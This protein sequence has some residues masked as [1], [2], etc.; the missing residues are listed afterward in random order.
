MSGVE[1]SHLVF[2]VHFIESGD[3]KSIKQSASLTFKLRETP[4]HL[5]AHMLACNR[6]RRPNLR[7]EWRYRSGDPACVP[8]VSSVAV[9]VTASR[10]VARRLGKIWIEAQR[11]P[12][13]PALH[14]FAIARKPPLVLALARGVLRRNL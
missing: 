3:N 8:L 9:A 13:V 11:I 14:D 1:S 6:I 12:V 2:I 4:R 5:C 7:A 10:Q